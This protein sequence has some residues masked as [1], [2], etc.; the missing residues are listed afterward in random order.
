VTFGHKLE[1]LDGG[2]VR[3]VKRVDVRRHGPADPAV[4]PR[5]KR[6]IA[7]SLAALERMLSG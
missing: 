1:S 6:D 7:E 2:R 5:M 4:R 3:V